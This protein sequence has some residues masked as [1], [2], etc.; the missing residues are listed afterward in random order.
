VVVDGEDE[1]APGQPRQ[2][3][4]KPK[5]FV[6]PAFEGGHLLGQIGA[7]PVPE[8]L[9]L[10]VG[11]QTLNRVTERLGA[12]RGPHQDAP[13]HPSGADTGVAKLEH[14]ETVGDRLRKC[15]GDADGA[16]GNAVDFHRTQAPSLERLL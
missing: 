3:T 4:R 14:V 5:E 6:E 15:V 11:V 10:K 13:Q 1:A 2:Q 9:I 7:E 12:A 16:R 8:R